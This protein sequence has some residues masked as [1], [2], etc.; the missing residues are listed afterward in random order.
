MADKYA[1]TVSD[2]H[3]GSVR[4]RNINQYS[5]DVSIDP[6]SEFDDTATEYLITV[7]G[8]IVKRMNEYQAKRMGL[9]R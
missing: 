3:I 8:R 2:N 7:N 5:F 1:H 9:I 4:G 6:I